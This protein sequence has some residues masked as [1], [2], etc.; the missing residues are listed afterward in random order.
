MG[1]H[2]GAIQDE[3]L[4]IWVIGKMLVHAIPDALVTPARKALVDAIPVAIFLRQQ[5]PLSTAAG[6]PEYAFDKAT[7][8]SF[9]AYVNAWT[10]AQKFYYFRPL[11]IS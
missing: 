7:A 8:I 1:A 6:H 5:A 4:H 10:G 9:L 2:D 3:M 11:I